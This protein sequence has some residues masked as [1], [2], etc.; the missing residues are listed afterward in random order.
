MQVAVSSL[1]FGGVG[2]SG[3]GSY[4]GKAILIPSPLQSVLNKS[5]RL[6]LNWRYPPYE[7]KLQLLKQLLVKVKKQGL[8]ASQFWKYSRVGGAG[9]G[10]T[11]PC[12]KVGA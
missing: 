10:G 11:T 12:L 3:I 8:G 9:G 6:D 4:H 7:G 2:D 5:F 1:P